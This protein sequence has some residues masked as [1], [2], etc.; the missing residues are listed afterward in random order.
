MFFDFQ[1][2]LLK[3]KKK[4]KT[5]K[6]NFMFIENK[7]MKYKLFFDQKNDKNKATINKTQSSTK[8]KNRNKIK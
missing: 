2:Q 1:T 3:K 8:N 7:P 6:K 4:K 5:T